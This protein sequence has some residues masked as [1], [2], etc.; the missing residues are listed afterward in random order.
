MCTCIYACSTSS[1]FSFYDAQQSIMQ[2]FEPPFLIRTTYII[3]YSN[4]SFVC[5]EC[6]QSLQYC[7]RL[8]YHIVQR[9]QHYAMNRSCDVAL[10]GDL[11]LSLRPISCL[12]FAC[13][14]GRPYTFRKY[15]MHEYLS[16]MYHTA[17]DGGGGGGNCTIPIQDFPFRCTRH[18]KPGKA[19]I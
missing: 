10:M 14:D 3:R 2:C 8:G 19:H 17:G 7:C 12:D 1:S 18:G 4:A 13:S 11:F 6:L 5:F 16:C 9:K 15:N